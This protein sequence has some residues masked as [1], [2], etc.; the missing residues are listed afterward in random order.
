[1]VRLNN[2]DGK[3][4]EAMIDTGSEG[5]IISER[6]TRDCKLKI[7]GVDATTMSFTG[8]KLKMVG[9]MEAKMGASEDWNQRISQFKINVN[10]FAKPG[11]EDIEGLE[12]DDVLLTVR[13]ISQESAD[14]VIKLI[15]REGMKQYK[16]VLE[17]ASQEI[18]RYVELAAAEKKAARTGKKKETGERDP[19]CTVPLDPDKLESGTT[20]IKVN[21]MYKRKGVKIYPVDNAPLDSL[22]PDGDPLW[23]EKKWA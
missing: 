14:E 3:V 18:R 8:D 15:A 6:I 11:V 22:V 17:S 16:E 13:A 12:E 9:Q 19:E 20:N 5:N 21:T 23:K 4:V 1:M 2:P 10:S 7:T